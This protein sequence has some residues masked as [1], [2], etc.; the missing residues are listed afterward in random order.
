MTPILIAIIA[1]V[2]LIVMVIA[3]VL[4]RYKVAGPHQAYI[5]TG[6]K[7]SPVTSPTASSANPMTADAIYRTFIR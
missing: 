1:P 6:R 4:S 5:I 7:G 2:V 3:F